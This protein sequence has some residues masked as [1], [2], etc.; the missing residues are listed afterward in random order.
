MAF[1]HV[2]EKATANPENALEYSGLA[3]FICVF[4]YVFRIYSYYQRIACF[5]REKTTTQKPFL[6]RLN[7]LP[8]IDF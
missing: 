2:Y 7:V 1:N 8:Y 3:L 6:E 5:K 4:D